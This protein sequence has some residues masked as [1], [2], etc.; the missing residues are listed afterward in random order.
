M[1]FDVELFVKG[2]YIEEMARRC[3]TKDRLVSYK[4]LSYMMML[5]A[6]L[7]PQKGVSLSNGLI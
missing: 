5:E 1:I 3:W 6:L 2:K 7:S 4:I